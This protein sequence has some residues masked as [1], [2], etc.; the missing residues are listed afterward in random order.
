MCSSHFV[1][2]RNSR[3]QT[4]DLFQHAL[5]L[6]SLAV[7][8]YHGFYSRLSLFMIFFLHCGDLLIMLF[9]FVLIYSAKNPLGL[10][11]LYTVFDKQIN[12]QVALQECSFTCERSCY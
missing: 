1:G 3:H 10:N 4:S 8:T 2:F 7:G 5:D 9:I 6:S 12:S 11:K